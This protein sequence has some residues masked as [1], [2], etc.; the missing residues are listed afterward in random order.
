ML[1]FYSLKLLKYLNISII[2]YIVKNKAI[3]IIFDIITELT[4]PMK[5]LETTHG[6]IGSRG[7]KIG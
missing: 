4:W 2:I 3:F 5:R 6:R 1:L 7:S